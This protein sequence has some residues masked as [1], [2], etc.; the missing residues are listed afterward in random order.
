MTEA[1]A[2]SE[3]AEPRQ[4]QHRHPR[5]GEAED[6]AAD[7]LAQEGDQRVG[8]VG[9]RAGDVGIGLAQTR[10][11]DAEAEGGDGD[12][13]VEQRFALGQ[14]RQA[15]GRADVAEDADH[16]R[17]IGGRHDGAQQQADHDVDAGRQMHDAGHEGD[18]DQHRDDRQQQHGEDLVEQ[19]A[20]VD[21]QAGGEQQGRQE[22]RQEDIGADLE[23]VEA[24]EDVAERAEAW[25]CG[26][27]QVPRKPSAH[28]GDRQQHGVRQA[29]ALG[30][31]HQQAGD[32]QHHRDR[33]QGVDRVA[34][35]MNLPPAGAL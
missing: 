5:H 30:Q 22:Q 31:R 21:G 2:A 6:D 32:R 16:R 20:H 9:R 17:R 12:R 34:H 8:H 11:L 1:I 28:A 33:E 35:R 14:D 13:V 3:F 15:L 19:A 26:S 25:R 18:A 29:Q 10:K 24:D 4:D 23:L 7:E 27:I